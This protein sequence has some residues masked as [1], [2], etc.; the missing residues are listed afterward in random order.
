MVIGEPSQ[1]AKKLPRQLPCCSLHLSLHS[2]GSRIWHSQEW[3]GHRSYVGHEAG[4]DHEV[5]HPRGHGGDHRHL[6]PGGGSAYRQLPDRWHHPLQVSAEFSSAGCWPECGA[7]WSGC[8]LCHW[9]RG[10]CWCSGHRPAATTVRGHDPDPD[11]RGG[12]WPL[13]S[14]RGPNPLHKVALFHHQSQ[15]RM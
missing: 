7:E 5:H 6:R 9:H 11:L 15:D 3:H 14:H 10:G 1:C 12:A 13:R 2:H 8:W 4:D